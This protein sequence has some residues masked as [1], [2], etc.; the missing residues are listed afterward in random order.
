MLRE[1]PCTVE[2]ICSNIIPGIRYLCDGVDPS[3]DVLEFAKQQN[4]YT[5]L[6][7][8][9]VT[10]SLDTLLSTHALA[11][12][13]KYGL[14][15]IR[16][17][18]ELTASLVLTDPINVEPEVV[19]PPF[20]T[21][22]VELPRNFFSSLI[23]TGTESELRLIQIHHFFGPRLNVPVDIRDPQELEVYRYLYLTIIGREVVL[24]DMLPVPGELDFDMK[25]WLDW[26]E[27]REMDF[28][29][30]RTQEDINTIYSIRRLYINLCLYI[31]ERGIGTP[32]QKQPKKIRNK[33]KARRVTKKKPGPE[34]QTW[35]I[36]QEVKVSP[37]VIRA[38]KDTTG[39]KTK[40][41]KI[42]KRYVVRGHWRNQAYGAK[43]SLRRK[44]WIEPHWRG[45]EEGQKVQHLYTGDARH[46]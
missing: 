41:W 38:A 4:I 35:I 25:K 2:S 10:A 13:N 20:P 37:E 5:K 14:S 42:R 43:R 11:R 18:E 22:Y 36:G 45:P 27:E 21:Y 26:T 24:T 12:W 31:A 30:P 32:K 1:N 3:Q 34:P 29:I 17:T 40:G 19:K 9:D 33:A 6:K 7:E 15:V 8:I 16:P 46:E 39:A 23:P 28:P 44:K